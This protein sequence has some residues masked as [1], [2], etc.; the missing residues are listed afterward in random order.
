MAHYLVEAHLVEGRSVAE[1]AATHGVHRS[2]IYKLVARY[3]KLGPAGLEPRSRRPIHSPTAIPHELEN[4]IV[5]MRKQLSEE[6][7]DAGATTIQWHLSRRDG[8]VPSLNTIWRVLKRRGFVT[9][10]PH[11]RPKSSLVRFQASL[12]NECWQSDVTHFRLADGS[13]LEIINFIDDHSRLCVGSEAVVVTKA[14]D[15]VRVFSAAT[16]AYGVPAALLTDNGCI[17]TAWHRGGKVALE[18]E[19][20]RL[21]VTHKHSRPYHPQTCGKVERF[22]QTMKKYLAKQ[23]ISSLAELQQAIDRFVAYYNAKRPHR[24][25][26]RRTPKEVYDEKVKAHP[27]GVPVEHYRVRHDIVD[28]EGKVTLRHKSKLLHI[29]IGRQHARERVTLLVAGLDVR[30]LGE[31]G[32]LIRQ[33][34]IDPARNYQAQE[35]G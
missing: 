30:V 22:H 7:L 20:E 9:P 12:P 11:K 25:I 23:D 2:W 24:G 17:Y 5:L 34:I 28:R 6:G 14:L 21:G 29:G 32:E 31:E 15:V 13:E 35:T 3:E 19:L 18:T 16:F 27:A 1:L 4:E 10:Q 8:P 26:G 33:L